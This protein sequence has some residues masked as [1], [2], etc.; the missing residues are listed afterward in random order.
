MANVV[1]V[2]SV[3]PPRSVL[4]AFGVAG[5]PQPLRGGQGTSWIAD[6]LV[7]KPG[8]GPVHD[9]FAEVASEISENGFRLASPVP[10]RFGTWTFEGW[11]AS[12][13]LPGD[14]PD[15]SSPEAWTTILTAGR[16]FHQATRQL[17]RPAVLST[18]DDWWAIA[19][20]AAWYERAVAVPPEFRQIARR[21]DPL[22]APLGASQVVHAD[23]T[24]N[25]LIEPGLEPAIIDM[26]PY[27]RP[28]AYAEGVIVAD[29][30]CWHGADTSLLEQLDVSVA[31]VARALIFR[32]FTT[33]QRVRSLATDS[34]RD[35]LL[36]YEH[37]TA[38]LGV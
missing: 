32:M 22:L 15:V 29:A 8:G 20:R 13:W 34:V 17:P 4:A 33:G 38:L 37:A 30:L 6:G 3:Q 25:V 7:L 18:R 2:T 26:S 24:L 28:S 14:P 5:P 10:T 31:A 23:L 19:D 35:E 12:K 27:W 36:R 11:A 9:W 16:A 1:S 21:L